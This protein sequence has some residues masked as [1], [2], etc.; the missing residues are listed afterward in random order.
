MILIILSAVDKKTAKE[1]IKF[2]LKSKLNYAQFYCAIPYPQSELGDICR[3][4]NWVESQD[5][6]QYELTKSICGTEELSAKE[7]KQFRDRA[8]RRFY[9]RPRMF[10]QTLKEVDSI[11]SLITSMGFMKWIKKEG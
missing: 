4:N 8:Y 6:S 10:L 2:V 1:T 7:I 5:Y 11:K 9:F 3:S